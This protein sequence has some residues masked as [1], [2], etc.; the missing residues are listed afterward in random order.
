M[1]ILWAP[2]R[3]RYVTA[4]EKG[5]GCVLCQALAGA[6]EERSL[7]VRVQ[8]HAFALMNL[9]PYNSGHVMIAPKRHIGALS[10][11]TA[12][13]LGEIMALAQQLERL[14]AQLYRPDGMNLGM[15]LGRSAGA[16]VADHIHL[17]LVPRWIGDTNFMTVSGSTRVVPEDPY[18]ACL[19]LRAALEK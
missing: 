3:G 16:G 7:V 11:A 14:Y 6:C 2:W 18:E 4:T 13:E 10:E 9:Y 5:G 19:R 15:N 8:E 17:H 1:E 12:D